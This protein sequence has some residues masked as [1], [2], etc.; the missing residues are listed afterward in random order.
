MKAI[1]VT[2]EDLIE[3]TIEGT[4]ETQEVDLNDYLLIVTG[5]RYLHHTSAFSNGT[6]V[7]TVK[8]HPATSTG[9]DSP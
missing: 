7:L 1:R 6:R 3:G 9:E 2:V 4:T 8:Q 5:N